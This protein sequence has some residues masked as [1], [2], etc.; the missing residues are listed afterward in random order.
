[1]SGASTPA[2]KETSPEAASSASDSEP[3]RDSLETVTTSK[4]SVSDYFRQKLR[5]K[6][7]ARQSA[8]GSNTPVPTLSVGSLAVMEEVKITQDGVGWAGTK[9]KFEEVETKLANLGGEADQAD[10][11]KS[12]VVKEEKKSKKSKG[13]EKAGDDEAKAAKKARKEEKRAKKE[14]KEQKRRRKEQ[15]KNEKEA[16]EAKKDRKD[17]KRKREEDGE[18]DGK[19]RRLRKD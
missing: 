12:E 15:K 11:D 17:K 14:E 10:E 2:N 5:E 13:K 4:M 19:N 3:K 6:A 7:L 9:M 8:S 16:K 1:M 18:E